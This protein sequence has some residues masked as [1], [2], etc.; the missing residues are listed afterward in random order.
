MVPLCFLTSFA[1]RIEQ[2]WWAVFREVKSAF[3]VFGVLQAFLLALWPGMLASPIFRYALSMWAFFASVSV[4]GYLFV[5]ATAIMAIVCRMHFGKGLGHFC[6]P[7]LPP[8]IV[9]M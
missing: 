3:I 9:T 5:V 1:K 7:F 2:G 8:P 6:R 4:A